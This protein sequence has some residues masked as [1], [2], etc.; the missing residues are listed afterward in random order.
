MPAKH[1]SLSGLFVAMGVLIPM[2]FHAVGLGSVFLPMFLPLAAAGFYL[3]LLAAM[4]VGLLTPMVSALATGMPPLSPP[5]AQLMALEGLALTGVVGWLTGRRL[6]AMLALLAGL[7]ASRAVMVLWIV[8]LV[9]LLGLP[10]RALSAAALLQGLPGIVLILVVV[11]VVL[12]RVPPQ[13]RRGSH[14]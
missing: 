12:R 14:A 2:V 11:P 8:A 13:S 3:P 7:A 4:S 9:P 5:V 10:A 1:L 6:P